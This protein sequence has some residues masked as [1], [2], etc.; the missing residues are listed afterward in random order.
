MRPAQ[1][2]AL[3]SAIVRAPNGD[4]AA[5]LDLPAI[6]SKAPGR[7][8]ADRRGDD[9]GDLL[10]PRPQ[11][12]DTIPWR[13]LLERA[14]AAGREVRGA[15]PVRPARR[16]TRS[17]SSRAAF[18]RSAAGADLATD[19]STAAPRA[20]IRALAA[21]RRA[22]P[23]RPVLRATANA[24]SANGSGSSHVR[25]HNRGRDHAAARRT[26]FDL[27]ICR[28]VSS[29]STARRPPRAI[30]KRPPAEGADPRVGGRALRERRRSSARVAAEQRTAR[31]SA[32][33]SGGGPRAPRS[34]LGR[35]ASQ[36][37]AELKR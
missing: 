9:Q 11:Q 28:N 10:L 35:T 16:R 3:R 33:R 6:R 2:P 22:E 7:S 4:A 15:P 18:A 8:N 37:I 24:P 5:F 32:S 12:L 30:S 25:Q 31:S 20:A 27:I 13:A 1:Q 21:H 23:A 29:T 34:T 14:Q 19:I 36:G 17:H 26:A